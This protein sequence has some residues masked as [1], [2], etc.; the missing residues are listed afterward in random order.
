MFSTRSPVF[1]SPYPQ[2]D[3]NRSTREAVRALAAA[4]VPASQWQP[5]TPRAGDEV[6]AKKSNR[7]DVI[8][9]LNALVRD[10]VITSFRTSLFDKETGQEPD[11][12]VGVA[13][14]DRCDDA[15][16]QVRQ[17]L[18]PLGVDLK[19]VVDLRGMPGEGC[20]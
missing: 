7:G 10:G 1:P 13:A 16:R 17:A 5:H 14:P 8:A 20:S 18:E 6:R 12:A 2:H 19:V 9:V 11:I 4:D 15:L 3:P